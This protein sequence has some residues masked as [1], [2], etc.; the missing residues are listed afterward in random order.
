M[1]PCIQNSNKMPSNLE[2]LAADRRKKLGREED[3]KER[4]KTGTGKLWG[5]GVYIYSIYVHFD[6]DG[7]TYKVCLICCMSEI[8]QQSY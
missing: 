7:G 6:Y 3:K 1:I 4:T 8:P 2:W 5:S